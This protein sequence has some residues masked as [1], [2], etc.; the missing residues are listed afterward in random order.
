M[1]LIEQV[2]DQHNSS[3]FLETYEKAFEA[4]LIAEKP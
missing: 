1:K 4:K 2:E 3:H